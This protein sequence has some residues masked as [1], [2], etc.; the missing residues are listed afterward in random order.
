MPSAVFPCVAWVIPPSPLGKN[1][2]KAT[3]MLSKANGLLPHTGRNLFVRNLAL[4][5]DVR[6]FDSARSPFTSEHSSKSILL[7]AA[8]K[9]GCVDVAL[10]GYICQSDFAT[11]Q[12]DF[13]CSSRKVIARLIFIPNSR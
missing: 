4:F 9:W 1:R 11:H 13:G 2:F 12:M 5:E 8:N 3:A 6:R 10:L 7:E